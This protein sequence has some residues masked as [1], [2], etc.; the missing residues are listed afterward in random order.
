MT[1]ITLVKAG[2]RARVIDTSNINIGN[3]KEGDEGTLQF[4]CY[5]P[6]DTDPI[7]SLDRGTF[8][9]AIPWSHLEI[10]GSSHI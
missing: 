7:L 10:I 9:V 4:D 2:V 5:Q 6:S 8:N 3:L 1:G